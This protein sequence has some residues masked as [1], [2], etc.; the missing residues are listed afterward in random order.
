MLTT[1]SKLAHAVPVAIVYPLL[2]AIGFN[3]KPGAVNTPDAIFGMT[4]VFVLG[5]ILLILGTA[6]LV[7]RWPHDEKAHADVQAALAERT[8]RPAE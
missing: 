7:S 1:T 6:W 8:A 3:P 2:G 5:P 4:L